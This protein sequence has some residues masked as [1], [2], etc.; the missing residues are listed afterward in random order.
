MCVCVYGLVLL[1]HSLAG[2]CVRRAAGQGERKRASFK[3]E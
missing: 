1:S 2:G 3:L